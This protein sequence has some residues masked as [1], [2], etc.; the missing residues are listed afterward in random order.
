MEPPIQ[1][2]YFLSGG[3]MIYREEERYRLGLRAA[4][5]LV[6]DGDDLTV[7]QLVALLQG[8]GGGGGGHLILEVQG[9]VAQL[10]LDVTHDLTLS[11]REGVQGQHGLNGHIHGR[12][13]E[14]LK[15][16]LGHLLPVG[17][18]VE[19]GLSKQG[20]VLFW[21]H[22]KLIVEVGN[23]A[24]LDGVLQSQDTP[25]A[26]GL[27]SHIAVLLTHTHHHTLKTLWVFQ[28]SYLVTGASNNGWEDSTG[29]VITSKPSLDQARA[30]VAHQGAFPSL[31]F[32]AY[33]HPNNT[34]ALISE[35]KPL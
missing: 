4:E 32:N 7:G 27:V 21:G 15:H 26:L 11:W 9:N 24:V 12:D 29:S 28:N 8:R 14:G 22:T 23:D 2:E 17:L 10:L 5:T 25:L 20:G 18:G 34:S 13:V 31:M 3:A 1:T 35:T 19:G 6:A 33:L 16:D 30:V